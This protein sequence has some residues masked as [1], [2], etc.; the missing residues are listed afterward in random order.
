MLFSIVIP[1]YNVEK[2]L[3]ECVESILVQMESVGN[4][5][6]IL[7][8]DD[9][10]TDGSGRICDE[11]ADQ[12]PDI[13][14]VFHKQNEGLLLTRRYGFKR[15]SGEYVINCDSDDLLEPDM[16]RSV[17]DAVS[18]YDSPDVII[19]NH[20]MYD[21]GNRTVAYENI[22]TKEHDCRVDKQDLL[23]EFMLGHSVVSVWGK[24]VKRSCISIDKDYSEFGRL[25]TGED[26]LQS[27]EL[28]SN[29]KM[30]V[31][32]NK[33][34]YDYRCGSGMTGKFD[35]DYYFTF[36][37][38]FEAIKKKKAEWKLDDFDELCAVKVLQ[39]AGRAITQS[40]YKKWKSFKEH[41]NYLK[42]ICDDDTVKCNLKYINNAKRYL[43]LDHYVLLILLRC[44]FYTLISLLL[45]C[46]NL[47]GVSKQ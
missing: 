47:S 31:Y 33:A 44:R 34:L 27:I 23:R 22:F 46:K 16:L 8:I 1:V 25:S 26:T 11:Y 37:R 20:N 40:R 45:Y 38:I 7:L 35:P 19:I 17:R 36:K 41:K 9:G 39:T 21:D 2:Y 30:Y 12:Y 15:S 28:F 10:S 24:I 29:S 5:C 13:I 14:R 3:K 32:L 18:K 4:S 43:Q 42:N 6:E